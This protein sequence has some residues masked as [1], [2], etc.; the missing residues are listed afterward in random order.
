MQAKKYEEAIQCYTKAIELTPNNPIYYG[1]RAAAYSHLGQHQLAIDD[2]RRAISLDPKYV[3]AYS[4]LGY[5][6]QYSFCLLT[7]TE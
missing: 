3:K 6:S 5:L 2:C 4:R 7:S 1:N